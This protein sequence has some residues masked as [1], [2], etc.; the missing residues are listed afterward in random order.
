[1]RGYVEFPRMSKFMAL[2]DNDVEFRANRDLATEVHRDDL[3]EIYDRGRIGVE[4]QSQ[5]V[6]IPTL[7]WKA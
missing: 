4:V 7:E 3:R 6:F 2:T 1:M 5:L